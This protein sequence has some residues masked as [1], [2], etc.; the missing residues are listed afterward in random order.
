MASGKVLPG[1]YH[2]LSSGM[3]EGMAHARTAEGL[4]CWPLTREDDAE[5]TEEDELE[6]EEFDVRR[7][8]REVLGGKDAADEWLETSNEALEGNAAPIDLF[9]SLEGMDTVRA[10]L[11]K[12][13]AG[14]QR[15]S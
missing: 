12:M 7:L 15:A 5:Y 11:E 1:Q 3:F 4:F 6:D 9:D 14:D 10:L 2:E 13:K 8:A